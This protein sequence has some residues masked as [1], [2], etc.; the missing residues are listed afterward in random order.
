MTLYGFK[1]GE[2][3]PTFNFQRRRR[4]RYRRTVAMQRTSTDDRLMTAAAEGAVLSEKRRPILVAAPMGAD[5]TQLHGSQPSRREDSE[6][7][8]SQRRPSLKGSATLTT[9]VSFFYFCIAHHHLNRS[10]RMTPRSK[11]LSPSP[12]AAPEWSR[13]HRARA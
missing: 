5:G 4:S 10:S 9:A 8:R 6:C 7:A 11:N 12:F 13:A 1:W 3:S 2:L